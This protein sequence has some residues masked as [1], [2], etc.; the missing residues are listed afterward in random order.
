VTIDW[1]DQTSGAGT[2]TGSNGTFA[3]S[4]AHT[5]SAGTL[6]L[7]PVSVTITDAATGSTVD[8]T[9]TMNVGIDLAA[10]GSP[11]YRIAVDPAGDE[12]FT[13]PIEQYVDDRSGVDSRYDLPVGAFPVGIAVVPAPPSWKVWF[14]DAG[15]NLIGQITPGAVGVT[16]FPVA[17]GAQPAEIT[18]GPDGNLWFTEP[19]LG[20]IGRLTPGGSL[21]E[22][23]VPALGSVPTGIAAGPDGNVW[24]TDSGANA[25]GRVLTAGSVGQITEYSSNLAVPQSITTGPDGNLWFGQG[26]GDLGLVTPAG[27][28]STLAVGFG[29]RAVF[30]G[31]DGN[32][33]YA[34]SSIDATVGRVTPSGSVT[35]FTVPFE[36]L[37]FASG[38]GGTILMATDQGVASFTP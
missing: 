29:A 34:D 37:G 24:F 14:A 8:T 38:S 27:L 15:R 21:S 31:P 23:A 20:Q 10:A 3:V 36:V 32:V 12:W 35:T 1:G 5:Y 33:W 16:V 25:I 18:L 4:G 17:A 26:G 11:V 28:V 7:L 13:V 22:F 30:L 9:V 2:L 6:G 19:G